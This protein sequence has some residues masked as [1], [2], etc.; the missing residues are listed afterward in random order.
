MPLLRSQTQADLIERLILHPDHSYTVAELAELLGVTDLSVRRELYRMVDAGI[1][2]REAVG[3]Q[4]VFR[5]STASPLYEPLRQL[6]ERSV[7][8][9][10]LLRELVEETPGVDLAAIYGSWARGKIDA[11]SDVDLLVVGD[12]DYASVVAGLMEIQERAGREINMVWMRSQEWH[13]QQDSG[14]VREI[15]ASPLRLLTGSLPET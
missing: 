6:V 13:E 4:S 2:D 12:I 9:E 10:A 7:G 5:A 3:R 15:L 14:F 8:L 11:E 1:I